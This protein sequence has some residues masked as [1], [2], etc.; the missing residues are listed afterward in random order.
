MTKTI[1][2]DLAGF[3]TDLTTAD[4]PDAVLHTARLHAVDALGIALASSRMDF[5]EAAHNAARALGTGD[6]SRSL[7]FGTAMPASSAALVNGVLIHGLDFDDTHIQAIHHATAPALAAALAVG[8]AENADGAATM[9]AYVAGLEIGCRL[10]AAGAGRF[11]DRGFHPTGI[12]GTFAAVCV[13]AKL[14]G[15]PADVLV[16]ALGL[17]GSQAA[18]ILEINE[19][20]LKRLHPG[21][22]AHSGIIATTLAQHGFRGPATVFE[23]THGLYASHLDGEPDLSA[24]A[25]GDLG[26]RWLASDIALKP[27]PC[28]HFTHAFV[29]AALEL[30]GTL[31][32]SNLTA[33]EID[34]I[35]CPTTPRLMPAVT[36][37]ADRKT[38]PVTIY[39][40]LFSVQY[41]VALAL[42]KGRVDLAAFYDEP[43]DD[44]GVLA[45]ARKVS[46]P[47]D[48]DSDYPAHFPGEVVLRLA[49]GRELRKRVPASSGTPDNP[50]DDQA[51]RE[52]F[53]SNAGRAL[54]SDQVRR[55]GECALRF[56]TLPAIGTLVDACV[57]PA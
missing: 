25:P 5:G 53:D 49:D 4:L 37:P 36:E 1:A 45:V 44:P 28:C 30:L 14:R 16:N 56:D 42:T 2:G 52:K 10:A 46:C 40:A 13:T 31:G 33:D 11:H 48:P 26:D 51:V 9:L 3:V 50:L 43:L 20:W 39:D 54:P 47:P 24:L 35:T 34:T 27:Y 15:L 6:D 19:S 21:W 17:A 55:L 38:A 22:A 23:G 57:V 7:G 18:G 29:D 12:A 32:R 8:E 41:A